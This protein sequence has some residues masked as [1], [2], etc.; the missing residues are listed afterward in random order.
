MSTVDESK[1]GYNY[2]PSHLA[3]PVRNW[4][5]LSNGERLT[6]NFELSEAAWAKIGVVREPNKPIDKTIRRVVHFRD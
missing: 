6:L 1:F 2:V 3:E 4:R 5:S